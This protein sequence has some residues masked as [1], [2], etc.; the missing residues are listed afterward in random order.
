MRILMVM[1]GL[2]A[3]AG[4]GASLWLN[5]LAGWRRAWV[6][7]RLGGCELE[8]L[9]AAEPAEN[10]P[11]MDRDLLRLDAASPYAWMSRGLHLAA[12]GQMES[13]AYCVRRAEQLGPWVGPVQARA[14]NYWMGRESKDGVLRTGAR[15]LA[16]SREYDAVVFR[17]YRE[18]GTSLEELKRSGVPE[19]AG[20]G[21]AWL[22]DEAGNDHEAGAGA[23]WAW[24]S[25]RGLITREALST[26]TSALVKWGR[27]EEARRIWDGQV[28]QAERREPGN[29]VFNPKFLQPFLPGPFDWH[30]GVCAGVRIGFEEEGTIQ[31]E[32]LGAENV[33]FQHVTQTIP[34]GAGRWRMKARVK[35]DGLSTNEGLLLRVRDPERPQRFSFESRQLSGTNAWESWVYDLDVPMGTRVLELGLV[36]HSSEK[37]DNRVRG[38]AWV[39]ALRLEPR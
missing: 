10:R 18:S 25:G 7:C 6:A 24:L 36:R 14:L 29:L 17:Y 38:V 23:A 30:V 31:V 16:I 37:L 12:Q 21:A 1:L 39:R 27:I 19:D 34:V 3:V 9:R 33:E 5:E 11:G 28:N 26:Y 22:A 20:A 15:L 2:A 13:G 35:S 8:I 32:F 4:G